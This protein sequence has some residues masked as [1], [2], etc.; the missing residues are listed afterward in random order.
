VTQ[1][2]AD[3]PTFREELRALLN[4]RSMDSY[5]NT[6]D[7]LLAEYLDE[8]LNLWDKT[9]E[10]R[11]RW[12]GFMPFARLIGEPTTAEVVAEKRQADE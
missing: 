7:Y 4:R 10:Q 1:P 12:F 2:T 6:P 11:D 3:Q 9:T 5:T 8:C